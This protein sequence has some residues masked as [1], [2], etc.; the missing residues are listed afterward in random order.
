MV[1]CHAEVSIGLRILIGRIAVVDGGLAEESGWGVVVE[2]E[3]WWL[4][5]VAA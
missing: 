5:K 1:I 2:K 4:S 3:G